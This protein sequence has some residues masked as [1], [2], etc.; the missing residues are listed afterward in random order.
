MNTRVYQHLP[1]TSQTEHSYQGFTLIELLV[2]ISIIAILVGIL[3]PALGRARE[4]AK[5]VNCMSNLRQI[6]IT[7]YSYAMDNDEWMVE[8][9]NPTRSLSPWYNTL[10]PYMSLPMYEGYPSPPPPR[11]D[12]FICPSDATE[13]GVLSL[14]GTPYGVP[15]DYGYGQWSYAISF[16]L[17]G[18]R[19]AKLP[20]PSTYALFTDYSWWTILTSRFNYAPQYYLDAFPTEMER[21]QGILSTAFA[22]GHSSTV[23]RETYIDEAAIYQAEPKNEGTIWGPHGPR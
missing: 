20:Q 6:G 14:G 2:V 10:R 12:A 16:V 1:S 18:R 22:D 17:E 4:S 19:L 7:S 13:G 8:G 11:V 5:M 9:Y 3:L 23:P 21:H 15:D